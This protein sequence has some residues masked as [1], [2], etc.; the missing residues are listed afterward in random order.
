MNERIILN[1]DDVVSMDEDK[2][3]TSNPTSKIREVRG[4]I[5]NRISNENYHA[6][7][8][9]GIECAVLL[10]DGSSGWMTGRVKFTCEFIPDEKPTPKNKIPQQPT[11]PLT[12]L[13]S[14]LNL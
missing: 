9:Q 12:N 14:E 2:N 3:L 4:K 10:G 13:R 5:Q 8:Q 6:W 7:F 1:D 11:S